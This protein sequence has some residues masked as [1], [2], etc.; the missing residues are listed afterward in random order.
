MMSSNFVF[1]CVCPLVG[2]VLVILFIQSSLCGW[3]IKLIKQIICMFVGLTACLITA[4]K[5][6]VRMMVVALWRYV[7]APV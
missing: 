1:T 5:N 6:A 3:S 2:V 4:W 7:T